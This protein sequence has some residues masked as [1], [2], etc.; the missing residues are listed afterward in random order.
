MNKPVIRVDFS[1]GFGN[2]LF[3]FVYA[4]LL[5]EKI[6]ADLYILP[7]TPEYYGLNALDLLI[8]EE[9]STSDITV[10]TNYSRV[11][12]IFSN[13]LETITISTEGEAKN[14]LS[15]PEVKNYNLKGYFEDYTLYK[16]DLSKIRS[17][18]IT[19]PEKDKKNAVLHLRLGDR[20]FIP[21]TYQDEGLLTFEKY[22]RGLD[23]I[24]FETLCIVSDLPHW[25]HYEKDE[26]LR[27]KYHTSLHTNTLDMSAKAAE[28]VNELVDKFS[29]SYKITFSNR[30]LE[31][32]FYR[33]M[34]YDKII[35][36]YSTFAWWAA[37]L[38]DAS[39]VGVYE[40]WRAMKK[41]GNKNLGK[42]NY[43]GWF[44]W[45]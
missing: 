8:T 10:I 24:D 40:P 34:C 36:G 22:K 18:F 37:V 15:K 20:L 33:L 31:S 43:D 6:G 42:T 30:N 11:N 19:P 9:V 38:S 12:E 27:C 32:D 3:Q 39:Q 29:E 28:Y 21:A 23:K 35:F 2:N 17:W 26:L 7:P 14:I 13:G 5:A 45:S 1:I 16:E 41:T 4:K 25:R 44:Q